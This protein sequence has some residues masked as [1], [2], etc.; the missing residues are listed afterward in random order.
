[1]C[2]DNTF[3]KTN[4][5]SKP[6]AHQEDGKLTSGYK[7][8]IYININC[9]QIMQMSWNCSYMD[10][11]Q[12][13]VL[14]KERQDLQRLGAAAAW[15]PFKQ[16]NQYFIVP[17]KS[18]VTLCKKKGKQNPGSYYLRW[19]RQGDVRWG[20]HKDRHRVLPEFWLGDWASM[21]SG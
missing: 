4:I 6:D 18:S 10:K 11:S 8:M 20:S 21:C 15:N 13:Y 7:W 14:R 12:Y 3:H 2:P 9:L 17:H 19:E 16:L 1:M 5:W